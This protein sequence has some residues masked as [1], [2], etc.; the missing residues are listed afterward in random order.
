MRIIFNSRLQDY[1]ESHVSRVQ[2]IEKKTNNFSY[3]F[4]LRKTLT[5]FWSFRWKRNSANCGCLWWK[6]PTLLRS[7]SGGPRANSFQHNVTEHSKFRL[8]FQIKSTFSCDCKP[9]LNFHCRQR[10]VVTSD[11]QV[12]EQLTSGWQAVR[13]L[14]SQI[15][16]ASKFAELVKS[17]NKHFSFNLLKLSILSMHM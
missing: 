9:A 15:L 5:S 14:T 11:Y 10:N 3:H 13:L 2:H 17:R 12:A 1:I 7:L 16:N 4:Y 8:R 6:W